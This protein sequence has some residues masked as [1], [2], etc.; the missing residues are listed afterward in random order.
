MFKCS[1]FNDVIYLSSI[2]QGGQFKT[3]EE[4][5]LSVSPEARIRVAYREAA[6]AVLECY[7]PN[8]YRPFLEVILGDD[9]FYILHSIITLHFLISVVFVDICSLF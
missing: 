9:S 4:D 1:K 7:F 2:Q 5:E 3:G 8:K 6:I